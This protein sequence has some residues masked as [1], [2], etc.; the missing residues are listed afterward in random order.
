MPSSSTKAADN[1]DWPRPHHR[2]VVDG[3]V[4]GQV[5]SGAAGESQGLHDIGVGAEGQVVA[6]RELDQGGVGLGRPMALLVLGREGGQEDRL[7]KGG[8][9]LAACAVGQGHDL[10]AQAG[11]SAPERLDAPEDYGLPVFR[12]GVAVAYARFARGAG[13]DGTRHDWAAAGVGRCRWTDSQ[14]ANVSAS[15]TS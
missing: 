3:P 7:E 6:R 8:R 5:A 15:W 4:H 11:T 10:I 14:S 12:R 2:Q 13:H 9:R 1:R